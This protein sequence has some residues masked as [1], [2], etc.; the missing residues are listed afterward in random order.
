MMRRPLL[1]TLCIAAAVLALLRDARPLKTYRVSLGGAPLGHKRRERDER[2]PEGT[3]LLDYRNPQS[4]AHLS[5]HVS[6]PVSVD[7]TRARAAG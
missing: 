5:L 4:S 3:Y 7:A 1:I 2:T 6:Y